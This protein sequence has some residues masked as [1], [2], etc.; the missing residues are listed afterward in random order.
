MNSDIEI[1]QKIVERTY[2][3]GYKDTAYHDT[4]FIFL[5]TNERINLYEKYLKNRKKIL[6]VT[7][8][9]DQILNSILNGSTSIDSFD[10]SRFPRY[11]FELKRSGILSLD[12]D[13]FLDFF[14][15]D[16]TNYSEYYDDIYY[17]LI[18]KNLDGEY[19]KFW[20]S[21]IDFYDWQYILTSTLFS[22]QTVSLTQTIENNPYLNKDK[23]NE[24]KKIISNA[25]IN[26]YVGDIKNLSKEFSDKYDLVNLSNIIHYYNGYRDLL[27]NFNLEDDGIILTYLYDV[28]D[29]MKLYYDNCTFEQFKGAKETVMIYKK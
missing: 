23:Y 28:N 24:L 3:C 2:E 27:S 6:S 25:N 17:D 15:K 4:S 19:K 20:D 5:T 26:H 22:S 7:S 10:I 29:T 12:Y 9:G 21:L 8:S 14:F 1:A 11:F 16:K 18:R 13:T